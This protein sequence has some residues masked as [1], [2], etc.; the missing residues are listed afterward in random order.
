MNRPILLLI[1]DDPQVLVAMR[2]D[3]RT[4]YREQYL[5]MCAPSGEEAL[6]TARELKAVAT[7]SQ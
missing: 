1:D 3:L 6:A 5:V 2:R 7:L 4:R